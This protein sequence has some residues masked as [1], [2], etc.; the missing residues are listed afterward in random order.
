MKIYVRSSK[1]ITAASTGRYRLNICERVKHLPKPDFVRLKESWNRI[2][3]GQEWD[4]YYSASQINKI[5]PIINALIKFEN[6]FPNYPIT[7]TDL[8]EIFD[9]T[10][11]QYSHA[12]VIAIFDYGAGYEEMHGRDLHGIIWDNLN[13]P[14]TFDTFQNVLRGLSAVLPSKINYTA[15]NDLDKLIFR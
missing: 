4:E 6:E 2:Q 3:R 13:Y 1:S 11:Y 14:G 5:K 7:K 15:T 8:D 9:G 10:I 12:L